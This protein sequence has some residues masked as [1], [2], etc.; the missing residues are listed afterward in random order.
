MARMVV[1]GLA[2]CAAL[3]GQGP[4]ISIVLPYPGAARLTGYWA[5]GEERIDWQAAGADA[6]RCTV[7]FAAAELRR[8]LTRTVKGAS[9]RYA[10]ALP[11]DGP[12]IVLGP[13]PAL[14]AAFSLDAGAPQ[15]PEAY[16]VR[17]HGGRL[18]LAGGGREGTLYAVYAYLHELGMNHDRLWQA[19]E[20]A[21]KAKRLSR[22]T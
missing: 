7:A 19:Y 3:Y 22:D 12:A 16:A 18:L 15:G 8:F 4:E 21:L 20:E 17:S 13:A 1:I 14:K 10:E 5:V 2:L 11:A 9:F 6:E